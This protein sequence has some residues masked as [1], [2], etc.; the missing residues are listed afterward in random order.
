MTARVPPPADDSDPGPAHR[1]RRSPRRET[2]GRIWVKI[3]NAKEEMV[4]CAGG[5]EFGNK[6]RASWLSDCPR[7]GLPGCCLVCRE[8]G[9]GTCLPTEAVA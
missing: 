4:W 1:P 3:G 2:D 7:C 6:L 9:H 5:C 8:R